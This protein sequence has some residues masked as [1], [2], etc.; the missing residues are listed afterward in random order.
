MTSSH[1]DLVVSGSSSGACYHFADVLASQSLDGPLHLVI[2]EREANYTPH[3]ISV[4][5][6]SRLIHFLIPLMPRV[7]AL[8]LIFHIET[9][10]V[11]DSVVA[12]WVKHGSRNSVKIFKTS[13]MLGENMLYLGSF[14]KL[15]PDERRVSSAEFDEFF[16]PVCTLGLD[17]CSVRWRSDLFKGLVELDLSWLRGEGQ[18]QSDIV[19][20][21]AACPRLRC[22]SVDNVNILEQEDT[23]D[24]VCL[25]QLEALSLR[26]CKTPS[27]FKR[28]FPLLTLS[29]VTGLSVTP[30]RDY[31]EIP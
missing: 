15:E 24:P 25:S 7:T 30:R 31:T 2:R 14:A 4:T 17:N 9:Q 27:S 22:L 18:T 8:E 16:R 19:K 28:L 3:P 6:I 26:Q 21:L 13:S 11:L 29:E 10:I 5:E 20:V 23:P 12:C 1:L